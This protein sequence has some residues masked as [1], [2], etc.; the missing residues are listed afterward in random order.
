[1]RKT[2]TGFD[3]TGNTEN[4]DRTTAATTFNAYA[5]RTVDHSDLASFTMKGSSA[6]TSFR[7]KGRTSPG[8]EYV[9]P[10]LKK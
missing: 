6:T 3:I 7:N 8:R 10:S 2:H 9:K 1:M 5:N 4:F